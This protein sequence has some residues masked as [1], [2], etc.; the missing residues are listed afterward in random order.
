MLDNMKTERQAHGLCRV[1]NY[2]YACGGVNQL[3]S[4]DSCERYDLKNKIWKEDLP[5]LN[6][7]KISM[8]MIVV[9]KKWLY[10]F[11]GLN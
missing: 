3:G 1:G 2:I 5:I 8:T 11:G 6:Q 7:P 10:C 4:L 9:D